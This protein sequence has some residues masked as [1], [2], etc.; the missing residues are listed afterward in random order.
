MKK[1]KRTFFVLLHA[2]VIGRLILSCSSE[3]PT[4]P[5]FPPNPE[6]VFYSLRDGTSSIYVM[7]SNGSNQTRLTSNLYSVDPSWSPDGSKIIYSSIIDE[8]SYIYEMNSDGSNQV[9]FPHNT[10][11]SDNPSYS[12]DG[13]IIVFEANSNIFIMDS[14]GS[15]ITQLT[16]TNYRDG[17]LTDYPSFSPDGLK[18]LYAVHALEG[19]FTDIYTMD[20]DGSNNALILNNGFTNMEPEYSP[21]G[22]QILFRSD[23]ESGKGRMR[24]YIMDSDASNITKI[25]DFAA[26]YPSWSPDGSQIVIHA[27]LDGNIDNNFVN[28]DIYVMNSDGSN[29]V[30]LTDDPAI[31]DDPSWI[32]IIK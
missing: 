22:T 3:S 27:T 17:F 1:P 14:G 10:S 7:N 5:E 15:N 28:T 29:I 4:E 18:I 21:N 24:I 16:F 23:L 26:R 2:F 6:I 8:E 30:R 31:D 25:T 12:P 20:L 32:P 9:R 19:F 13:S 11:W